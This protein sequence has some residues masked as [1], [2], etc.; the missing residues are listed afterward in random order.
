MLTGDPDAHNM[1]VTFAYVL[2]L[3]ARGHD[4]ALGARLGWRPRPLPRARPV[5][6][7]RARA[8][9]ARE[10]DRPQ[11]RRAAGSCTRSVTFH[12]DDRAARAPLRPRRRELVDPVR[13]GLAGARSGGWRARPSGTSIVARVPVALTAP[14]VRR[15][16]APVRAT[17]TTRS[18]SAGCLNRDELLAA[19]PLALAR[20]FLLTAALSVRGRAGGTGRPPQLPVH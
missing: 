12:D 17:A 6:A 4:A 16:P 8:R 13:G 10:G 3:A 19:V 1:L 15:H 18:T 20:E 5:G 14:V 7:A 11:S 2:A 9:L